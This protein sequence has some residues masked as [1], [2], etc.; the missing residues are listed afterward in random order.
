MDLTRS[1]CWI[2]LHLFLD[3]I[4]YLYEGK[5]TDYSVVSHVPHIVVVSHALVMRRRLVIRAVITYMLDLHYIRRVS[6]NGT[7]NLHSTTFHL[8]IGGGGV[9][10]TPVLTFAV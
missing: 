7:P 5:Y 1:G 6:I 4:V 2:N 10:N 8:S 3:E 9:G